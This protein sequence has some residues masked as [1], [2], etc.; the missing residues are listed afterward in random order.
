MKY[1][2][3]ILVF[4]LLL[5]PATVHARELKAS[6]YSRA[7]LVKEGTWKNGKS[8]PM[9]NGK[10]FYDNLLVAASRDYP[11]GS[12]LM[13]HNRQNGRSVSVVVTDRIGK[14]FKGK[15]IDLSKGAFGKIADHK[16]GIVE[17][18]VEVIK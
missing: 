4:S 2:I 18:Q 6:W 15:R 16:Q 17:V 11:L 14:R 3:K 12:R 10:Q 9:A 5:T 8:Q 7:S 13:V 1:L